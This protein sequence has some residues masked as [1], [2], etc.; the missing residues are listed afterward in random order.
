M[1]EEVAETV[2]K[3]E[4]DRDEDKTLTFQTG[5]TPEIERKHY[6][7]SVDLLHRLKDKVMLQFL[8]SSA[9]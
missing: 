9:K 8:E 2:K 1:Q 3:G 7:I 5:H 6:A 4:G